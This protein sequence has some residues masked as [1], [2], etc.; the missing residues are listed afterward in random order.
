L[1][2]DTPV[3][4]AV[5]VH[6]DPLHAREDFAAVWESRPSA[7][8]GHLAIAELARDAAGT[9]RVIRHKSTTT[10]VAWGMALL[11][12]ALVVVVAPAGARFLVSVPTVVGAGAVAGHL[13]R[14][15]P[16]QK[17]DR[18]TGLLERQEAGVVLLAVNRR[19]GDV[20]PLLA[21]ADEMFAIES[22]WD[23]LDRAIEQEVAEA[24]VNPSGT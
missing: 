24:Q 13:H 9:L 8:A 10:N 16:R 4:L 23:G 21:L 15:I 17:R 3:T 6:S 2:A 14:T 11:G 19:P 1:D 12:A 22:V 7:K 5:A 20:E 18:A